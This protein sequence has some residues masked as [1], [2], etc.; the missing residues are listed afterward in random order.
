MTGKEILRARHEMLRAVREFFY[1][2]DYLEVETPNLLVTSP[3]DPHIDPLEVR[4]G[5]KGPFFLH[6]SP[7]VHMKRLLPLG[8]D[9]IFQ[10]CK[11]YR[12]EELGEIHNTEFSMLEWYRDGTYEDVMQETADLTAFVAGA[13]NGADRWR[14]ELPYPVYEL[15]RL[16]VEHVG[17]DPFPL[18]RDAFFAAL[19]EKG[20]RGIDDRDGWND[21]FFKVLIQ[22]IEGRLAG[23]GAYFMK[24]WPR[25]I[26]TMAKA[27]GSH[28]VERFEFYMDGVEIA[29]GYTELLDPAEQRARFERDNEERRRLG[30]ETFAIDEAFLHALSR[31]GGPY[32]GVALGVDRLLMKLLGLSRIEEVTIHRFSA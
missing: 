16:F 5:E 18:S 15:D 22:E 8:Q 27:R 24:D 17:M 10:I 21:L 14:D 11:V 2:R 29:N 30:K 23:G 31:L 7:E 4:V 12:V 3:P 25:S 9:R 6:T 20:F 32:G 13:V 1:D 19:R 28:K 26:S